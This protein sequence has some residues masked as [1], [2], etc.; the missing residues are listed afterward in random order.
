MI[1][2]ENTTTKYIPTDSVIK[3]A[4]NGGVYLGRGNPRNRIRYL[5]KHELL[6]H[7]KRKKINGKLISFLP[8]DSVERLKEIQE[9]QKLTGLSI[10]EIAKEVKHD[11]NFVA[12]TLKKWGGGNGEK[13]YGTLDDHE[14]V[15][16]V[17]DAKLQ[18]ASIP[19]SDTA[20]KLG[21][22]ALTQDKLSQ[23][24]TIKHAGTTIK[25][26]NEAS[27]DFINLTNPV[28]E[29]EEAS[30]KSRQLAF[31]F[32]ILLFFLGLLAF[33]LIAKADNGNYLFDNLV[34][35]LE[36]KLTDLK[37]VKNNLDSV[38]VVTSNNKEP[39][40]NNGPLGVSQNNSNISKSKSDNSNLSSVSLLNSQNNE[41]YKTVSTK[42]LGVSDA[43][44]PLI[45]KFM[46]FNL[47]VGV[48][49]LKVS[50][51]SLFDDDIVVK[52]HNLSLGTGD[53]QAANIIY[54]IKAGNGIKVEGGQ[55]VKLV[56][57]GVLSIGGIKGAVDLG[58][59]LKLKDN[60]IINTG[61]TDF[62]GVSG[63]I[64]MGDGLKM[65][66]NA[67]TNTDKGSDQNIFKTITDG[68]N[69]I[70]AGSNSDTVNL[71]AGSGIGIA[72]DKNNNQITFTAQATPLDEDDIEGF[73]FDD[74]N[75]GTLSSGTL[76]FPN[77]GFIGQLPNANGGTGLDTST[78]GNGEL[79]IGNGS[80]FS[81]ATLTQG[82][83]ITINNT[84]G[85]IEIV[86]NLGNSIDSSEILDGE[87]SMHDLNNLAPPT[88]G[89]VLTY[90]A[91]SG[92][93]KWEDS[94]SSISGDITGIGDVD[95]GDA[96]TADSYG[97]ELW[98]EG[99]TFDSNDTVL[100]SVDP[101]GNNT[102][103]LPDKSGTIA[104]LS[105]IKDLNLDIGANS[106]TY[107]SLDKSS[108][109]ENVIV[110][111]GVDLTN[112]V[113]NVLP[114]ANGGTGA[115][116]AE[117]ARIN[118]GLQVGV[119]VQGFNDATSLLGNSIESDEITDGTIST[120]DINGTNSPATAGQV[121]SYGGSSD[122]TWI[123]QNTIDAG[124]IN[125]LTDADFL[126]SNAND[127]YTNNSTLTID[128]GSN[129]TFS[130][131]ADLNV[132]GNWYLGGNQ[133][134]ST[135]TEINALNGANVDNAEYSIL[136]NGISL[137]TET[138]GNYIQ[139]L[140]AGSGLTGDA[141]GHGVDATINIGAGNG[142]SV[143]PDSITI[144]L[145]TSNSTSQN[146]SASGLEVDS[147]GLSLLSGCAD[148]QVLAYNA[149]TGNWECASATDTGAVTGSGTAGTLAYWDTSNSISNGT[150]YWDDTNS[151]LGIN[152]ATPSAELDIIGNAI[153]SGDL[154]LSGIVAGTDNT[155][156][157]QNPS[158]TI[159]TREIDPKV[160][161]GQLL[162]QTDIDVVGGVQS[163]DADTSK[164][165]QTIES[166][167]I[168]DNT[169]LPVDLSYVSGGAPADGY[170]LTY[171]GGSSDFEWV[172]SSTLNALWQRNSGVLSPNTT[173]DKLALGG[174]DSTAPI[175]ITDAGVITF[176]TDT[177]LYRGAANRLQTDDSLYVGGNLT[178]STD[179]NDVFITKGA[180]NTV[181]LTST[182]TSSTTSGAYLVGFYNTGRNYITSTDVQG[183]LE[184]L[185]DQI[186]LLGGS[187]IS[188]VGNVSSGTAFTGSDA[189]N[190]LW[191]EGATADDYEIALTGADATADRIIT[192][193][194]STG[195]VA[196]GT[197]GTA[198]TITYWVSTNSLSN[199]SMYWDNTNGRLGIG[200]S[201]PTH[202]LEVNGDMF[203][204]GGG[205]YIGGNTTGTYISTASAGS[206]STDLYVGNEKIL[207]GNLS[208][209]GVVYV[210]SGDLFSEA[211]LSVSR[212]GTGLDA[213][214]VTAGQ[215]LIGNGTNGDF[216]LGTLTAGNG[217]LVT[218][219][220]GS[221]TL[222]TS[223]LNAADGTGS[224]ASYSGFEYSGT[225][226]NQ[227]SLMQGCADTQIL[228]W[229]D[230]TNQWKCSDDAGSGTS[231]SKWTQNTNTLY[232]NS[233]TT[234][235][236]LGVSSDTLVAPFSVD[237]SSNTIRIGDGENDTN[238]P[239]ITFYASDATNSG[240]LKFND[241]DEFEF[242]GGAVNLGS[243]GVLGAGLS[244]DCDGATQ[245]LVWDSATQQFSCGTDQGSGSGGSLWT[246][247]TN[248]T[249]L[250]DTTDNLSAGAGDTLV[251]PFSVEVATNKVRIG[252]GA[253]DTNDPE[254]TFYASDATN[255]G[256]LS[257]TDNDEFK[258]SGGNVFLSSDLVFD[259]STVDAITTTLTAENP[260]T[261]SKTITIP[262]ATGMIALRNATT[263]PTSNYV[264]YWTDSNTLA[265]GSI[266]DSGSQVAI[267][268]NSPSSL[269][270]VGNSNQ[271]TVDSSG[272]LATSGTV[273]FSGITNGVLR[274]NAS[275]LVSA[276]DVDLASEVTGTLPTTNGGTGINSYSTGEIIY[277]SATDTL[278]TLPISSTTGA[279][280][281]A[282]ATGIPEWVDTSSWDKNS[283][284]DVTT[285]LGLTDTMNSYTAGSILFTSSGAVTEDNSNFFFDDTN[286]RLGIALGSVA[287]AY[288]LDVGGDI[289]TSGD[290]RG[291]NLRGSTDV[292]IGSQ[293]LSLAGTSSTTSGAHA[294]GVYATGMNY[295]TSS[296]VQGALEELDTA[297]DTVNGGAVGGSGTQNYLT[298]WTSTGSDIT[299]SMVFDNGT[300]VGIN[301]STPDSTYILD[302]NGV[303]GFSSTIAAPNIGL[304]T[305]N[306][307]VV[308]DSAGYLRTDEIDS[309]VWGT[310]LVDYTGTPIS[311]QIAIW[312]DSDTLNA[313]SVLP[314]ANGGTGLNASSVT[315]GQLLI[316]NGTDGDFDLGTLTAGNGTTITNSDGAITI[317]VNL[318]DALDSTGLTSS[319]SGL[320]YGGT[321]SNQLTLLQG[322]AG[323]QILKWNETSSQWVCSDDAGSG[324]SGSP[325]T[326]GTNATYLTDT[327][328]NFS[329]G[330]GDTLT[331]PFS[332][333]VATNE[334]RIGDGADDANDPTITFY[335]SDATDSGILSYT[336]ADQFKFSGGD[337]LIDNGLTFTS[338]TSGI[339]KVDSSGV[340]SAGAVDLSSSTEVTN[341][342]LPANGGTG[343]NT[344]SL[345]GVPY[346]TSGSGWSIDSNYLSVSHGGT[347]GGSFTANAILLGNGTSALTSLSTGTAGQI[348]KSGGTS[349]P[350]W[351]T[352]SNFLT[353][354]NDIS[355]TGTN[356]V[357][358][359]VD[360][361]I[362][363]SNIT[364]SAVGLSFYGDTD[365]DSDGI[366]EVLGLYIDDQGRV[367]IGGGNSPVA[368]LQ[369]GATSSMNASLDGTDDA[370]I[371]DDLEV[372]GEIY[373]NDEALYTTV[374][375]DRQYTYQYYVSNGE[376]FTDSIDALDTQ[377]KSI[378]NGST[379]LWRD[380]GTVTYLQSVSSDLALGGSDSTAPFFFD[381]SSGQLILNT[382]GATAGLVLGSDTQLYRSAVDTLRT[383]DNLVVDGS[384][385]LPNLSASR[386]VALDASNNLINTDLSSWIN[387]TSNEIVVTDDTD[388]TVTVSLPD[389][390]YLGVL[391]KI[392]RDA[393]NLVDFSTD[394]RL[395]WRV[396][397]N[398]ELR[399]TSSALYPVT[400][401]GLS[402]G[403]STNYFSDL[404]LSGGYLHFD[405]DTD[406]LLGYDATNDYFTFDPDGDTTPDMVFNTS[407]QLGIGT[408]SPST[409]L[410]VSGTITANNF[411]TSGGSPVNDIL[412]AQEVQNHSVNSLKG[413]LGLDVLGWQTSVSAT[414]FST[415]TVAYNSSVGLS[416]GNFLIAYADG[417]ASSYGKF[418]V[419][420]QS[421]ASVVSATEF[422]SSAT[423]YIS[424]TELNNGNI[425]IAYQDD[426]DSDYGKFVIYDSAGNQIV[427]PTT[428]ESATT[429]YVST[430]TLTNGN[431]LIAYRD[432]GNSN[433]GTFVIYNAIGE[434]IKGPIIFENG[435]TS[436]ISTST[437]SDGNVLIAYRDEGNSSYGTFVV[438]SSDGV[439]K[440]APTVFNGSPTAFISTVALNNGNTA[441]VYQ[442]GSTGYGTLK[443]Y[444]SKGNNVVAGKT[445]ETANTA[446]INASTLSSGEIF[447]AYTDAGNSN[448]GTYTIY[449]QDGTQNVTPTVFNSNTTT[450]K[451][452][453]TLTN[454]KVA[455]VYNTAGGYF[456]IYEGSGAQLAQDLQVD[457]TVK[458]TSVGS[459]TYANDLNLTSDGT[460]TTSSSDIRL[461]KDI[462]PLSDSTLDK[463][464]QLNPVSFVW[465]ADETGRTDLGLIAQE[466]EPIF[467]EI[468]FTNKV[469]GY[470][471]IN[472]SR[473]TPI[474]IKAV[475]EQQD[476]IVDMQSNLGEINSN[477]NEIV[478]SQYVTQD[479]LYQY[480]AENDSQLDSLAE[481][482][483]NLKA[484]DSSET[485]QVDEN[486][487]AL[488]NR[489]DA[490]ETN[491]ETLNE[492]L[493]LN[494]NDL[495]DS[496]IENNNQDLAVNRYAGDDNVVVGD[497]VAISEKKVIDETGNYVYTN[498]LEKADDTK[499]VVGIII[500]ASEPQVLGASSV[501][502][503]VCQLVEEVGEDKAR[504]ELIQAEVD[505]M[506][507]ELLA[508]FDYADNTDD[509]EV[510]TNNQEVA[511][512]ETTTENS[513]TEEDITEN[514]T[515]DNTTTTGSDENTDETIT[516]ENNADADASTTVEETESRTTESA[517]TTEEPNDDYE[518]IIVTGENETTNTEN[519]EQNSTEGENVQESIGDTDN[520]EDAEN[521]ETTED[522]D[523]EA[524]APVLY[525]E[526]DLSV[527]TINEINQ[528]I[529]ECNGTMVVKDVKVKT[530]GEAVVNIDESNGKVKV[531]DLL[532]ISKDNKGYATKLTGED[533]VI[534]QALEDTDGYI[535][536]IKVTVLSPWYKA[537]TSNELDISDDFTLNGDS[538]IE[539]SG[540]LAVF[541]D[542]MFTGSTIISDLNVNGVLSVGLIDVDGTN[543]SINVNGDDLKLQDGVN[544]GN[545][546]L[547][548][549]KIVFD[550]N[551]TILNVS[552]VSINKEY[553]VAVSNNDGEINTN[554]IGEAEIMAGNKF[555]VVKASLVK[556][557][558]KIFVT[559]R[560][561]TGG[562][563]LIVTDVNDG[564][565]KVEIE[566]SVENNIK[567]DYW[568]LGVHNVNDVENTMVN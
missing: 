287:P 273:T 57:D 62:A 534:A 265:S 415:N 380:G 142:I 186:A 525:T 124:S 351:D 375:G 376:S 48:D 264:G 49:A 349:S 197:G 494:D 227:L 400:N 37:N 182:G 253:N 280:L 506:N 256:T 297:I 568:I 209:D 418:V 331:S 485:E 183:A 118:L 345:T 158:N 504:E 240:T 461:K 260:T 9:V 511:D 350:V 317:G 272:N 78:A 107:V 358:I 483:Q 530:Q 185:D 356:N 558:S 508:S 122:F 34:Y 348:L 496:N 560:S 173:T 192:L 195:T 29:Y 243:T 220:D 301:T 181:G 549:G 527:E 90:D 225:S 492:K 47:P 51:K 480:L 552:G 26:Q 255:S 416:N 548:S 315:A 372:D 258:F 94:D 288:T 80:G 338:L 384:L 545:I 381:V 196:L 451:S 426:G 193:P 167:E 95:S 234:D 296:N 335:A 45:D 522:T 245:K 8:E 394:D 546:D 81:L 92:K 60:Q 125:G 103:Y 28:L 58:Q 112:D 15:D 365:S 464:L 368:D 442:D 330:N 304:G 83:G 97:N 510:N 101:T 21:K 111:N 14:G 486:M 176:A 146:Q 421:G 431:V 42:V 35:S 501:D 82:D 259:G 482:S 88:D 533:W 413:S 179:G 115:S 462:A 157:I 325:W 537:T 318:L 32:F 136:D 395:T 364:A 433:Y 396:S 117:Q 551:G 126:R 178:L 199:T 276:G 503:E 214:S 463:V 79:L 139:S 515:S 359:G 481:Q 150:I 71:V 516:N 500:D 439:Q 453:A 67:L 567:F 215:L 177:N 200:A 242:S 336:D 565:F 536:T 155:V 263:A 89:Q 217:L 274:T 388:G 268:S 228:K 98:F 278:S 401:M 457:G 523:S 399:L 86:S 420:D 478:N 294:I 541:G 189:G 305:D 302:V 367:N 282:S 223:I 99:A 470:M 41:E 203:A 490:L 337:V 163:Y 311:N 441:I 450:H 175:Y 309:R 472:Y 292:F 201:S 362:D 123:D 448:Y 562:Q 221:I 232:P 30:H 387:G 131:G 333:D 566:K 393:D 444:D 410:D 316:G 543:G 360:D 561:L 556:P 436:Y 458:F 460:L 440:V 153:I 435:A 445:F 96:F 361:D 216:D 499:P 68:S 202:E 24:T 162:D 476:E 390:V 16:A 414:Q 477:L 100:T 84:A 267:G 65:D 303:A 56:N 555:V 363:V 398:D 188:T 354:G 323:D 386:L 371:L 346:V 427:A 291:V 379:G 489:V 524:I 321:S 261:T 423:K 238:D 132:N 293:G 357:T 520:N 198:N 540:N 512:S 7:Q 407:G 452:V 66:G 319:Y 54:S 334:V 144:A 53:I 419:Y 208:T 154:T 443:I 521:T 284:D 300:S 269:F 298:K 165:G 434:L 64:E 411:M 69:S 31:K 279:V 544:P 266:Y 174:T 110:L 231:A 313:I 366:G 120:V 344:S 428:F 61:I 159:S 447:I 3:K 143:A 36:S 239:N 529:A 455:L 412:L 498:V 50:G 286:N 459:G 539:I 289:N 254:I 105:D 151:Y 246:E 55:D 355:L 382:D 402:L 91:A 169:I 106:Y 219:A 532:T 285:F 138:T 190:T 473:L 93:F 327:T 230:V 250:T 406:A 377:V 277:A 40:K 429:T 449:D 19:N 466:V 46:K 471:G 87:V 353:A 484:Q 6:P 397:A 133:V 507:E 205:I 224:T 222:A 554:S 18:Y 564:E 226:S 168:T 108:P 518:G 343:L 497:V 164:L 374:L 281:S 425:F 519:T 4:I 33:P 339:L 140:V 383:P 320:E 147:D 251:A 77:L 1:N 194:D 128:S 43:I 76:D 531:G 306:S 70:T 553:K 538:D 295:V 72:L 347:G 517:D 324:T 152:N 405:D 85:N 392:G 148:N 417:G 212:G 11:K 52:N 514:S 467:P 116:T 13:I 432:E 308:L 229:D 340:T 149:G 422:E 424:A 44:D 271:F 528:Q 262:N 156:L 352:F 488:M 557:T 559:A 10:P 563:E 160:W 170:V 430:T 211:Q 191:F 535:D 27:N 102:L 310:S 75:T 342:L 127:I 270:N 129:I 391:G 438:Y 495:T 275:G 114:I 161:N 213:S 233:N 166:S 119:D 12:Q 408:T 180:G 252:D 479:E 505:K 22:D 20:F 137:S 290:V 475:Q 184:N 218:N 172:D 210:S 25:E 187:S 341:L 329:V 465:K 145:A 469:D 299:D 130:P 370:Y 328:A 456:I 38:A 437:M 454:G 307:V 5:I 113:L 547:F 247:G 513:D 322:C 385:R 74:D 121:L 312:S 509:E 244:T 487:V 141:T 59:G 389:E 550:A 204:N 378:E 332:I 326:E 206:S 134:L 526:D 237:I 542:A 2:N 23:G 468:T 502:T 63:P 404:Y 235:L 248:A 236:A 403:T 17:R 493:K 283:N 207:T 249:Y 171:N 257:Y 474:L 109:A 373:L 491:I 314:V 39:Q 135:A 446:Y 409:L 73:I 241:N 369:I 104:V